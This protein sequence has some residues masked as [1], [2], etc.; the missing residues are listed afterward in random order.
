MKPTWIVVAERARARIFIMPGASG[1]L[2]EVSDLS[3]PDSRLHDTELSSDL[4][5]RTFDSQGQSR[6]AMEP[7]TDPKQREAQVFAADIARYIE[8]GRYQGDFEALVLV[9]PPRFL[10]RL[11]AELTRP[12]RNT[13][14]GELDKNLVEAD[15]TTIEHQVSVL[16][17]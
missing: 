12:A 16:L 4:P 5:G 13:L 14:A 6:H 15:T 9:A 17:R 1:K 7:A 11:R 8:R 2:Q 3:H 10:G